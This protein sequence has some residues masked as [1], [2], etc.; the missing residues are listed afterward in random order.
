MAVLQNHKWLKAW[1]GFRS[2]TL[3]IFKN[4]ANLFAT[5]RT[6]FYITSSVLQHI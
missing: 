6:N 4:F 2:N 3:S 1:T 5:W